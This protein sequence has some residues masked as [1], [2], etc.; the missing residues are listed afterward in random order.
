MTLVN[1]RTP[2]QG[3]PGK[4]ASREQIALYDDMRGAVRGEV[5]FES[6]SRGLYSQDASNFRHPPLGVVVPKDVADVVAAVGVCR[7]HGVPLVSRGGGTG[8]GGSDINEA[9]V[10]LDH[11]KYLRAILQVDDRR[12][13][14]RV[15][16]GAVLDELR[17]R[18]AQHGLTYGPDPSTHD[19]CTLGG[20]IG[21]N[22][23]GVHA[24]LSEFYGPGPR[25]EQ[26]VEA[27]E[28]LTYDGTRMR[29]GPTSDAQYEQIL[30]QGGRPAEIHRSLRDLRD[31][32]GDAIRGGFPDIQRRVSGYNLQ[33]L[34][35]E[36]GFDVAAALVGTEGTCATVLEATM[37]LSRH[38]PHQ[39]LLILGYEDVFRAG[40]DVPRVR[41][42]RPIGLEGIDD[43][44]IDYIHIKG[45]HAE[46]TELLPEGKGWLIVEFGG[47]SPQE[48]VARARDCMQSLERSASGPSRATRRGSPRRT[49]PIHR[50]AAI[51]R[52]RPCAAWAWASAAAPRAAPCV[53]ATR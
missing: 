44:L 45:M 43:L 7:R 18:T 49:S 38:F 25:T 29:V 36:N 8:I 37:R 26:N 20:M 41:E 50:T 34:L 22:A 6:Q 5:R 35:P 10:V 17:E 11:S 23:C 51:S 31:R 27:L 9:A 14:A 46:Y 4:H 15:Q 19:R 48:A 3:A 52:M 24:V 33:A 42:F 40:D 12:E 2:R 53:R 16:P 13:V 1:V 30:R 47:D 28:V 32:Y 21:T 39:A